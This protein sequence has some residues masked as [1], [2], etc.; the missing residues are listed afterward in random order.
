MEK[1]RDHQIDN[2]KA[3][4]IF[5][6][7]LGHLLEF[8]ITDKTNAILI[9]IYSFHMPVFVYFS[10]YLAKYN[11]EKIV[12]KIILPY[13]GVQL[14]AFFF[15]NL[16]EPTKFA[17][18][19]P[20]PSL[21]YMIALFFWYMLIPFLDKIKYP[22]LSLLIF[23]FVG[24]LIGFD[25]YANATFS[26]SRIF[27]YLP[28]FALGYF[29]KKYNWNFKIKSNYLKIFLAITIIIVAIL[30]L[31]FRKQIDVRWFYGSF[32][33]K[34]LN[35]NS[36]IRFNIYIVAFLWLMFFLNFVPDKITILSKIGRNS[37]FVYLPHYMIV[38]VIYYFNLLNIN[39]HPTIT[40]FIYAVLITFILSRDFTKNKK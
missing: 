33:Y 17:L 20:Y 25:N 16:F 4:M 29:C 40:C 30:L 34:T 31:L 28:F 38:Y 11:P 6:V 22:K 23:L 2:I 21:W 32:G 37:L 3:I 39:N 10:G 1:V 7:V 27:V 36:L 8:H 14:F 24:L 13:V 5:L 19:A 35:F 15:Y 26:I 18:V 9:L 12:K